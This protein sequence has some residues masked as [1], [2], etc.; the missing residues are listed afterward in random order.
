MLFA[1]IANCFKT[2]SIGPAIRVVAMLEGTEGEGCAHSSTA[3]TRLLMMPSGGTEKK[4]IHPARRRDG[5][6]AAS[7]FPRTLPCFDGAA[8]L[9]PLAAAGPDSRTAR[10]RSPAAVFGREWR[11]R[12]RRSDGGC[13]CAVVRGGLRG[14]CEACKQADAASAETGAGRRRRPT[15]FSLISATCCC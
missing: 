15:A 12:R 5:F 9:D 3:P 7:L 4:A 10:A 14:E 2:V 13:L 8:E 11:R 6:A 1:S